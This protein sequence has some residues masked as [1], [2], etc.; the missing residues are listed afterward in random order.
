MKRQKWTTKDIERLERLCSQGFNDEQ[1][2]RK[3]KRTSTAV[4]AQRNR[5]SYKTIPN[6]MGILE[7]LWDKIFPTLR[8]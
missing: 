2:G 5:R 6:H 7:R 8:R 4:H 1:I 3:M